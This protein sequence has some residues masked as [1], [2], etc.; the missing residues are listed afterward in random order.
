MCKLI[1]DIVVDTCHRTGFVLTCTFLGFWC[2]CVWCVCVCV[3]GGGGG[4]GVG[5]GAAG[6]RGH[7]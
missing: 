1:R 2:V 5:G 6:C 3:G 7:V 4:G